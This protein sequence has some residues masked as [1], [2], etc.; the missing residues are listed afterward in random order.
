MLYVYI[1]LGIIVILFITVVILA[2][3]KYNSEVV[4]KELEYVSENYNVDE[5]NEQ[6]KILNESINV[7]TVKATPIKPVVQTQPVV[8]E[9]PVVQAQ[10]V[11]ETSSVVS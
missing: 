11:V 8:Q 7:S 3:G 4:N 9:K 1:I 10:T 2:I 6:N 5:I